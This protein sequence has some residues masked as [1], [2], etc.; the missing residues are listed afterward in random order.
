MTRQMDA[1]DLRGAAVAEAGLRQAWPFLPFMWSDRESEARLYI[2][3]TLRLDDE[4]YVEDDPE[5][6]A[7]ALLGLI[8]LTVTEASVDDESRLTVGFDGGHLLVVSGTPANTTHD[9]W[10]FGRP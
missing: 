7:G 1:G 8:S 10:W 2:D 9:V 3:T 6:A 5:R 4:E